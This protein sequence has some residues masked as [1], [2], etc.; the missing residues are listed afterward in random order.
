MSRY[1]VQYSPAAYEDLRA[2]YRYIAWELQA[3]AT[4]QN[5]TA[6]IRRA[7]RTLDNFPRRHPTLDWEPWMSMGL[8]K[9]PVDN[10]YVFYRVDEDRA[11]VTI[12]R[13][14]YAGRDIENIIK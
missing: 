2:I 11:T 5:Q 1:R 9:M 13:I 10:Y 7:V 6:R 12:L 8:R 4:A 3:E 14:F